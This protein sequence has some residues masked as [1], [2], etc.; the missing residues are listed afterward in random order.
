MV[1]HKQI[2]EHWKQE[3]K[4][5]I[6]KNKFCV[7]NSNFKLDFTHLLKLLT[8]A[9]QKNIVPGK[10]CINNVFKMKMIFSK[11]IVN[12]VVVRFY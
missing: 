11:I 5:K 1:H 10:V 4:P 3:N 2:T 7:I 12:L 6:G 9:W 8:N